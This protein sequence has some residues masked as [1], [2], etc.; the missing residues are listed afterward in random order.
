M[1][2]ISSKTSV[3]NNNH[4]KEYSHI[5]SQS[6][7]TQPF[8]KKTYSKTQKNFLL[9]LIGM[10][11]IISMFSIWILAIYL[12]LFG[13][14]TTRLIL[15]ILYILQFFINEK[16]KKY[17][18][19]LNSFGIVDYFRSYTL[20]IEQEIGKD[21][22]LICGHPHGI[23]CFGGGLMMMTDA[24]ESLDFTCCVT[25]FLMYL[26]ISGIFV[27]LLGFKGANHQQFISL[28]KK[29]RNVFFLP[30]GFECAASTNHTKDRAFIKNR[31][32]F[33]K[34]ALQNGYKIYPM[35]T[36][37]ENKTYYTFNFFESLR[38]VLTKLKIPGCIFIGKYLIYP[39]DDLDLLTVIG[40]PLV[41]PKIDNP[42]KE[43][44][45]YYH[46]LYVKSLEDVYMKYKLPDSS[47]TLEII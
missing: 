22:S 40:K 8:F 34:Y 13:S 45:I 3:K 38:L 36:F 21:H 35:Y 12:F 5:L 17:L 7:T 41:L 11:F 6:N 43:D 30:G 33:I 32:G 23:I 16:N 2:E 28:L 4:N 31:I 37:N 46:K 14:M 47:E 26:P 18:N 29:G 27:R 44:V 42:S 25:R 15:L 19:F 39:K 20:I 1:S 10:T 24:L 9:S